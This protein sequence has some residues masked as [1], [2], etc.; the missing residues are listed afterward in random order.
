VEAVSVTGVPQ[1]RY[2]KSG[3]VNI[4]YQVFGDGP[5][6]LV[7]V[8]PFVSHVE[9]S[10]EE[11]HSARFLER[12]AS[13]CRVLMFD[14]RGTGMSDRVAINELPTLE[15]RMDDV[16]AVMDAAGSQRGALLGVSEG[17]A[18][19]MMFAATYPERTTALIICGGYARWTRDVDYP[20]AP[21]REQHE[22]F[23]GPM[24]ASW[25]KVTPIA[26][27]FAPSMNGDMEF[28][29]RSARHNRLASSPGAAVALYRMNVDIDT[30]LILSCITVPTLIL[31]RT[32]DQLIR[33]GNGRYLAEHIAGA[34]SVELPGADHLPQ[35]GDSEAVID[36]IEEFLTG[37]RGGGAADRVL[38]TVL[39][40]DIVQSTEQ[41]VA[42]GDR[43]W[44]M[45]LDRH[46][47]L[48]RTQLA[49]FRGR[50]VSTAGDSFF[51]VFDGPARAIRCAQA[52]VEGASTLGIDVRA[53]VHTGEV[54][55]RGDDYG[56][57]AVHIGARVAA[58][59]GAGEV[60]TTSTVK[61]LVAG[62]GV[63]FSDL[64]HH[65]LKG[66]PEL[67]HLFRVA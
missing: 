37:T 63:A 25:G 3:D 50:E 33:I 35:F 4:A 44:R 12:L 66:V 34:R 27:P 49:R 26:A 67:W 18:M 55:V 42:A 58:L 5:S 22:A 6:D 7:F 9:M 47:A 32:D 57:I 54:E 14:K 16:R 61:D 23:F 45:L 15:Q 65:E 39:F 10:W 24:E 8:P 17:G 30:R 48:V 64:G 28:A 41:L 51:A 20:A 60:F 62:S 52:I 19:C 13:F 31:H 40:T 11:P 53:G 1:T 46:D 56:G 38:A 36:E 59:A 43:D 29:E 21:T 2:A